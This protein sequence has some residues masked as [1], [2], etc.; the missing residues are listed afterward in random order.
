MALEVEVNED[1][2]VREA[3]DGTHRLAFRAECND[4]EVTVYVEEAHVARLAR[5]LKKWTDDKLRE[6]GG[7]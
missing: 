5:M 3:E 1:F 2:F 7:A 4:T 6:H